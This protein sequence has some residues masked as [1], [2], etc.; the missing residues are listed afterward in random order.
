MSDFTQPVLYSIEGHVAR[1][2]LN[3]PDKR[4]ALNDAL[5]SGIKDSVREADRDDR[6]RVV[7]ISGAGKDFCSGADLSAL[8]KIAGASVTE[9]QDDARSLMELFL[10]LRALAVPVVAAVQGR[11]LAGGCGLATACDLVLAA[12]SARFGYP[13][14]RIGFVP[15]MVLAILRRN[16][17][18]KNA[19]SLITR[20]EQISAA[21][22]KRIGLVN[23]VFSE[24]TFTTDVDQYLEGF[25]DTSKSAVML[26]KKLLYEID[27][28]DLNAALETGV[29]VN[30]IARMTEDC[31]QG[32]AK[33]L[34]K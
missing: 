16:V 33:F 8:Q 20:G 26:T 5:I 15:A 4:N 28:L 18:E 34:K 25:Y 32:I 1:I 10:M 30:V 9:N 13:E 12:S 17:S 3:R 23:E 14:V 24:D 2:I 19:F 29:D 27:G 6:V 22:A 31:K 11:A 21:E 7:A